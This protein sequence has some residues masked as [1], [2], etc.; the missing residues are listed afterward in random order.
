MGYYGHETQCNHSYQ[1]FL[2]NKE[3]GI[4]SYIYRPEIPTQ[5]FEEV[6]AEQV[7]EYLL[8]HL[9]LVVDSKNPQAIVD[10]YDLNDVE[11][12]YVNV[13]DW[14]ELIYRMALDYNKHHMEENFVADII[15][16][17][18]NVLGESYYSTGLTGYEQYYVDIQGF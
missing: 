2:D 12:K 11:I 13:C 9:S 8:Q 4:T 10:K 15:K 14:R 1:Y 5:V 6:T 3:Y 18:S 16:N 17:N 7:E